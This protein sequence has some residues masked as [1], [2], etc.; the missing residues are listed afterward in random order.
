[1]ANAAKLAAKKP[2]RAMLV[3]YPGAGKTGALASLANAGYK[4][5]MIDFDGNTDP[6]LAFTKPEFLHNID[7]VTLEDKLRKGQKFIET[8]GIPTAFTDGLS[9]MD[10]WKYKDEDG[11]EVDLGKSADWG[12]DTIVVLDS[13][14]AMGIAAMRRVENLLNKTP[15]NR[16]Q[17]LWGVSAGEQEAFIEKLTSDKN[18]FHVIVLAHIKMVGPKDIASGDSE[19][20]K[21]LKARAGDLIQTRYFPSALGW[22]LPQTIGQHFPTLL[23]VELKHKGGSKINRVIRTIPRPDLDIKAPAP[24]MPD[25]VPVED[26]ML[27]IFQA[28]TVPLSKCEGASVATEENSE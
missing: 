2:V 11:T 25:E 23:S 26:G 17:Q 28:L 22:A 1:M 18:R 7:I 8:A 13:L 24:D 10:R 14:T 21:D 16:T 9:L 6:L 15:L 20:T 19:L 5:R 4:I 3:G 12:C 27:K